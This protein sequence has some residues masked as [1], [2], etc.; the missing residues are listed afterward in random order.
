MP[1]LELNESAPHAMAD[2]GTRTSRSSSLLESYLTSAPHAVLD[3]G[4]FA[5]PEWPDY[6]NFSFLRTSRSM[7]PVERPANLSNFRT[8][9][10]WLWYQD[11]ICEANKHGEATLT[12]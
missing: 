10:S 8:F 1:T 6:R 9:S 4:E 3:C 5:P 2:Y 11:K 12:S 7:R